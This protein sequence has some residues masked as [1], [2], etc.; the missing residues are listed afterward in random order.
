[1]LVLLDRDG[2]INVDTPTGVTALDQFVM[3]P[4]SAEA[5]GMLTK[6]GFRIA[7]CTNQSAIGDGR[8]SPDVLGIIH[9][10]MHREIHAAGGTIDRVYFAPEA[11]AAPV[12]RRKPSPTML[13]E[14]MA[15]FHADPARTPFV[16]DMIRDLEAAV[17]AGCPRILTRTGKG[18][19]LEAEGIPAH[20]APVTIVDDLYAAVQLILER[21][22]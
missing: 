15:E 13:L 20:V 5:I 19:A 16:G 1:M 7:V 10:H 6:A 12:S 22:R 18:A 4:R 8:L 11:H 3:I 17:A 9:N 14:A 21:Y 2:V